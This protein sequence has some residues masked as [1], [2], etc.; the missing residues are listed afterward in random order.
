MQ[1]FDDGDAGRVAYMSAM[2]SAANLRV[3]EQARQVA[4]AVYQVTGG[5]PITER[6]GLTAQ[7]R[8]SAV[9]IGSNIC[10]GCGRGSDREL[11]QFLHVSLGSASELE[12]QLKLAVDLAFLSP[13]AAAPLTEQVVQTKKMLARLIASLRKPKSSTM[14]EPA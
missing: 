14:A 7:M 1:E 12:F 10:E 3:T 5:F 6:F 13:G 9:S 2:Q 8:K 11:A 4:T